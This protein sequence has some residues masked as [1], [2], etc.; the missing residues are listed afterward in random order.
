MPFCN[1]KGHLL[2][3]KRACFAMQKGTFYKPLCNLLIL[4]RLQRRFLTIMSW[5]ANNNTLQFVRVF[6]KAWNTPDTA[7]NTPDTASP[8]PSP[9]GEGEQIARYSGVFERTE[10]GKSSLSPT[11]SEGRGRTI[12]EIPRCNLG[13]IKR[14]LRVLIDCFLS[15]KVNK[16]HALNHEFTN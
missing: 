12:S 4:R 16:L 3:C 5:F 1:V 11:L 10:W 9:K 7:C 6:Q 14:C 8:R 2:M 15:W 13:Y